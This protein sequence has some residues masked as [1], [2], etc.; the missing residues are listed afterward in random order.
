MLIYPAIDILGGR[1][2][3]LALGKFDDVT[4]YGDPAV[5]CT[6]FALQGATWVHVVDLDG[7][8]EGTPMQHHLLR[9]LTQCSDAK[10]QF[11]GGVRQFAHVQ[12]LFD[13]GVSRVIVG[14]AAVQRPQEV[15]E[16]TSS[17][18]LERLCCAL[19]VRPVNGV[20][21]VVVRGWTAGGGVDL[22]TALSQ[23]PVGTLKHVLVTDVSRDG[24][25]GGP[26]FALMRQLCAERPDLEIQA[27]G[28]V[29]SLDDLRA[30]RE[31]GVSGA[32]VG[33]A[34]YEKR[35]ALE[36]AFAL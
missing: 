14:S 35:V 30:L 20:Y 21:E 12:A 7:A 25:L 5:Q 18:G 27:S 16:W 9:Q 31:T 10:I 11:G 1:C 3:R 15:R 6:A 22:N 32:I 4:T 28:G 19:D 29:A 24:V 13:A 33:R 8:R 23:F 26:N 36:E 34:L 2:V 17:F